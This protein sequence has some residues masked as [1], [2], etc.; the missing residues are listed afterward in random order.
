MAERKVLLHVD[1]NGKTNIE[2]QG[3]EG[4]SCME[5]TAP[6]EGMFKK[7]ERERVMT[8]DC[9]PR[10]DMGERVGK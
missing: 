9:G 6:F 3:Y 10:P 4:G 7:T 1:A 2:A 8:G 5:A